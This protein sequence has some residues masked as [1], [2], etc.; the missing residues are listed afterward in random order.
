MNNNPPSAPKPLQPLLF[1]EFKGAPKLEACI[2]L[3]IPCVE[4]PRTTEQLTIIRLL[5]F[6]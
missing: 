5:M 4:R 1:L 2:P 6:E 3:T